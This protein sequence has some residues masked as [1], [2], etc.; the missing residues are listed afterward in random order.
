MLKLL[1]VGLGPLGRMMVRD[2]LD[3][4][5]AAFPAAVDP[6]PS[7]AGERLDS[8]VPGAGRAPILPTLDHLPPSAR[9]DAAV[10]TTASDLRACA[11][12]FRTLLRRGFTIVSTCEELVWPWLR[13]RRLADELDALARRHN[14]RL[15]GT[16]VNP[17]MMMDALPLFASAVC[18]HVRAVEIHRIQD[19]S[20]RRLP[21]QRK[22]GAGLSRRDFAAG[23]K[24]GWLRHVGLGESMHLIAASLGW[25]VSAW[26]ESIGPVIAD[27]PVRCGLGPIP[28]G[29]ARGVRQTATATVGGKPA[30]RMV[31]QAAIG[32]REP[33]PQDRIILRGTPDL[34]LVIAGGVHGDIATSAI[35][36]NCVRALLAAPPGLHT[37]ASI[38]MPHWR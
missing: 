38:P 5:L 37:M 4:R 23:I 36:L 14:G 30:I 11:D 16:G 34:D 13:H 17:G 31:F 2:A 19:A 25:K 33:A 27:R 3:R 9:F 26:R 32:Q 28:A 29:H 6:H 8:L 1:Q 35:T 7:I 24:A 21:F 12:T 18:K 20:T 22:I 10:V 15:L